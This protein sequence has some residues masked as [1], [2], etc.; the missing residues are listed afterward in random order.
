MT[1]KKADVVKFDG[2]KKDVKDANTK[3]SKAVDLDKKK[4]KVSWPA[5]AYRL[6]WVLVGILTALGAIFGAY[7]YAYLAITGIPELCNF[8]IVFRKI[9]MEYSQTYF[10]CF[11]Y[12]PVFFITAL[13]SVWYGFVVVKAMRKLY[14]WIYGVV[15]SKVKGK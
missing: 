2:T 14:N 10:V 1:N 11:V 4:R 6:K 15:F 12:L 8:L 7:V 5:I 9:P 3:T 13:L